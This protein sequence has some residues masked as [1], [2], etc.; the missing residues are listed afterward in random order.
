MLIRGAIL[1]SVAVAADL[2]SS[3][4]LGIG[5]SDLGP[6]AIGA[7]FV[8]TVLAWLDKLDSSVGGSAREFL[9]KWLRRPLRFVLSTPLVVVACLIAA[10][11]GATYSSVIIYPPPGAELQASVKQLSDKSNEKGRKLNGE[12]NFLRFVVR[13]N[14]FGRPY[15]IEVDGYVS[16]VMEV[17]PLTGLKI[18][19][20]QDL[21]PSPSV[22]LRPPATVLGLLED[23]RLDVW[24]IRN[25][26]KVE[27]GAVEKARSS[28]LIGRSRALPP[29]LFERWRRELT[30][31]NIQGPSQART[32][33]EW[34]NPARITPPVELQPGMTL[35]AEVRSY[36]G[37][38]VARAEVELG[39][40]ALTD[41][42]MQSTEANDGS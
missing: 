11:G 6:L 21:P 40:T 26:Q 29:T 36:G 24:L 14:P 37:R 18:R 5:T 3:H 15:R 8:T 17:P 34:G 27:V 13:T 19:P 33:M 30:A 22:L 31:G 42:H 1:V 20:H 25:G 16:Q 38:V 28:V 7:T 32:L 4:H 23:G 41:I 12:E 35:L 2:W 39:P 10:L 9:A